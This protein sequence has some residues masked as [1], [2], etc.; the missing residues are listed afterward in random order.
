H[1]LSLSGRACAA[2]RACHWPLFERFIYG[3]SG[4][5]S[6]QS[7]RRSRQVKLLAAADQR[8]E[9]KARGLPLELT[10]RFVSLRLPDGKLEVLVTTLLEQENYPTQEFMEVYH[11]RW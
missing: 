7:G 2:R 6:S 10:V 8:T 1:G 3:G 4:T 11:R 5:V 9:L